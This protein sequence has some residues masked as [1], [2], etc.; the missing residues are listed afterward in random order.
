M[1][2]KNIIFIT[3][4]V[5][6]GLAL[7]V[8]VGLV[9]KERQA[10][11]AQTENPSPIIQKQPDQFVTNKSSIEPQEKKISGGS[12]VV[13]PTPIEEI[14]TGQININN[15]EVIELQKAVDSGHQ[16][17]RLDPLTAAKE[18]AFKYGFNKDDIFV[19]KQDM[20]SAAVAKV[21]VSHAGKIYSIALVKPIQGED[22]IWVIQNIEVSEN[23]K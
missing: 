13:Y 17:W 12:S 21:E 1:T 5:F 19:L 8:G 6:L 15:A 10:H 20:A 14:R 2:Q 16:P 11:I 23:S 3:L 18:E 7:I 4:V 22:K 9:F